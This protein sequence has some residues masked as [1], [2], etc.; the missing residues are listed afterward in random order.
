MDCCKIIVLEIRLNITEC[1]SFYKML[2]CDNG[3]IVYVESIWHYRRCFIHAIITLNGRRLQTKEP[4]L[5]TY[6][7]HTY[8]TV[9]VARYLYLQLPFGSTASHNQSKALVFRRSDAHRFISIQTIPHTSMEVI[10]LDANILLDTEDTKRTKYLLEQSTKEVSFYS[11]NRIMINHIKSLK[12]SILLIISG[13]EAHN[14]LSE[15]HSMPQLD[16]VFI[17]CSVISKYRVLEK[18]YTKVAGIFNKHDK[19]ISSV[20]FYLRW[21][22]KQSD[23][24]N[25]CKDVVS[26]DHISPS[27]WWTRLL[28]FYLKKNR[29]AHN[30]SKDEMVNLCY[31][32][33][34]DNKS[35]H[36][37][38]FDFEMNYWNKENVN[39]YTRDTFLYRIVNQAL[40]AADY[41]ALYMLRCYVINL[42]ME[43]EKFH[44]Q[45]RRLLCGDSLYV[46]RGTKI[47]KEDFHKIQENIGNLVTTKGFLSTTV[48]EKIAEVFAGIGH[49]STENTVSVAFKI[50]MNPCLDE[51]CLCAYISSMSKISDEQEILFD[52]GSVF[53]V[54]SVEYVNVSDYWCVNMESSESREYHT[55]KEYLVRIKRELKCLKEDIA[56]GRLLIEMGMFEQAL[57]HHD[58]IEQFGKRKRD[59]A[60]T[61]LSIGRIHNQHEQHSDVIV[62]LVYYYWA[63]Q[64]DE[65]ASNAYNL[66]CKLLSQVS[67][68]ERVLKW[69][70]KSACIAHAYYRLKRMKE[71][72]DLYVE[73]VEEC[74]N[75]AAI[76]Y[77]KLGEYLNDLASTFESLEA[78]VVYE[79]ALHCLQRIL[80]TQHPLIVKTQTNLSKISCDKNSQLLQPLLKIFIQLSGT[81]FTRVFLIEP[82][83][84]IKQL[85]MRL[86]KFYHIPCYEQTL[87]YNSEVLDDLQSFSSY[88]ILNGITLLWKLQPI[89]KT[90]IV[91]I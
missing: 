52:I 80:P 75:A 23:V 14:V 81:H 64:H 66:G 33:F 56:C 45:L 17:F 11:D 59:L 62:A 83:H 60:H 18:M 84:T 87:L 89:R 12:S 40:R 54:I 85:K 31:S 57:I 58:Q 20:R 65:T 38:I 67:A 3:Y 72:R 46:Y 73:L 7:I 68:P 41:N 29:H 43:L 55:A 61:C 21:A 6:P 32:Y 47:S 69:R 8:F 28:R 51:D 71:A 15:I 49:Q 78:Y 70:V 34:R 37:A 13:I 39:W 26:F 63:L 76:D 86:E 74:L 50:L 79:C 88:N 16:T 90:R 4:L 30:Y 24:V 9:Y 19:M 10:W 2:Y 36:E 44:P 22:K 48:D 82:S 27:L 77:L 1:H 91:R 5:I 53:R 35:Y 42:S 25:M